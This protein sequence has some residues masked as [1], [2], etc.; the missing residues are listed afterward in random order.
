MCGMN[1]LYALLV[2]GIL[3]FTG[4]ESCDKPENVKPA[5]QALVATYTFTNSYTLITWNDSILNYDTANIVTETY[6]LNID[7][8]H[9]DNRGEKGLNV[10]G[11]IRNDPSYPVDVELS[12]NAD[13]LNILSTEDACIPFLGVIKGD[14][15]QFN[16]KYSFGYTNSDW[17]E[18][19]SGRAVKQ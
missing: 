13:T 8:P 11:L 15:I 10:Y 14:T 3:L 7:I 12:S 4:L 19:G 16:Y 6:N 18:I 1:N 17:F 9:P 5:R 2:T